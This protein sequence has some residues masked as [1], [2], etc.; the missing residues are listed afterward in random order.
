M[1][2]Q[3]ASKTINIDKCNCSE[4]SGEVPTSQCDYCHQ[5]H[6]GDC[7]VARQRDRLWGRSCADCIAKL[8]E[9]N[10]NDLTARLSDVDL[11]SDEDNRVP[12]YYPEIVEVKIDPNEIW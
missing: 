11:D 5:L 3:E 10:A 9:F 7:Q 1:S 4:R 8:D 12:N 2:N 6:Y